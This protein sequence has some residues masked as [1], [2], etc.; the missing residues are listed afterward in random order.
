VTA[1]RRTSTVTLLFADL[2]GSTKMLTELGAQYADVLNDYRRLV[3]TAAQA[4]GGSLIDTTGDGL[5]LSFPTTSGAVEAALN[6][7][8]AM[9]AHAWPGE[10][11]VLAR[12]AVHTGEAIID[13][14]HLVGIDVHRAARICAAG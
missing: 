7:Q 13:G 10:R 9:R 3:V 14:D 6:S 11:P 1:D 4:H 5:F 2:E 8:R 12:M